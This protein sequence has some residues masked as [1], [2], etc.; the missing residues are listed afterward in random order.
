MDKLSLSLSL[1]LEMHGGGV[2]HLIASEKKKMA[3]ASA[4]HWFLLLLAS[5]RWHFPFCQ[6]SP[7]S[8]LPPISLAD[9]SASVGSDLMREPAE[10]LLPSFPVI[11]LLSLQP[12]PSS[13]A[14]PGCRA[15]YR[16]A[17][18]GPPPHVS[19]ISASQSPAWQLATWGTSK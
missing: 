9:Y 1:S 5:S 18:R 14:G 13:Q 10:L 11:A 12:G 3:M 7:F 2:L 15:E 17:E 6:L 19:R 8:A 16:E 4:L